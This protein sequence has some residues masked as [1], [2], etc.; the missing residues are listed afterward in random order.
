VKF[1]FCS[2]WI[3]VSSINLGTIS[4]IFLQPNDNLRVLYKF[5]LVWVSYIEDVD[6]SLS[7]LLAM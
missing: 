5:D 4:I 1:T 6:I 3:F 7:M 2:K